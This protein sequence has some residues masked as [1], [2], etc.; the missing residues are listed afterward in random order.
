M[1]AKLEEEEQDNH[2][3]QEEKEEKLMRIA[4]L[5]NPLS[6]RRIAAFS[7][8]SYRLPALPYSHRRIP[9]KTLKI[10]H[11]LLRQSPRIEPVPGSRHAIRFDP[12]IRDNRRRSPSRVESH[13]PTLRG[14]VHAGREGEGAGGEISGAGV[15]RGGE[16]KRAEVAEHAADGGG[17]GM[18]KWL[19]LYSGMLTVR[20]MLSWFPNI[21]W[22]KQPLSAIRD[23]CDPYLGLFR[24]G[25]AL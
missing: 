13:R 9:L 7:P 10:N 11:R 17:G 12:D 22:D 18:A 1:N 21:Q 3:H 14:A 19:D 2:Y 24:D 5:R 16:E 8:N 6:D 25:L 20:C 4:I 23:L 15:L